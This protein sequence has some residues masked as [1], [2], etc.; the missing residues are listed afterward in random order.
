MPPTGLCNQGLRKKLNAK[1]L[2]F[3]NNKK[4]FLRGVLSM[5]CKNQLRDLDNAGVNL[6]ICCLFVS[7]FICLHFFEYLHRVADITVSADSVMSE[8]F[9]LQR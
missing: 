2:L 4:N 6:N 8:P 9:A 7:L 5:S 1:H 3:N